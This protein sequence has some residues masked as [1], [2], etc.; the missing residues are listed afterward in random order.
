MDMQKKKR[1]A[2]FFRGARRATGRPGAQAVPRLLRAVRQKRR[3][4]PEMRLVLRGSLLVIFILVLGR[5]LGGLPDIPR[6]PPPAAEGEGQLLSAA[7][8]AV[9][10][11]ILLALP[12]NGIRAD[13]LGWSPARQVAEL[14]CRP[15]G[16]AAL[17]RLDGYGEADGLILLSGPGSV[18]V[19]EGNRRLTGQG[20]I[21]VPDSGWHAFRYTCGLDPDAG[22]VAGFQAEFQP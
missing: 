20:R 10:R 2:G 12:D 15:E 11:Q 6:R 1:R 4:T 14:L 21:H 18:P 3:L 9:L 7:Q 8:R 16:L 19:L 13:I 22:A 5:S 17:S